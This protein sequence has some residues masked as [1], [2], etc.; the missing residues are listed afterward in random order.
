MS[1]LSKAGIATLLACAGIWL[2]GCERGYHLIYGL[3][4]EQGDWVV[5]PRF[6]KLEPPSAGLAAAST[7]NLWGFIDPGGEWT[8]EPRF[9]DVRSFSE[10][11]AAV[12][13][14]GQWRFVDGSGTTVIAGPFE[15]VQSFDGGMAAVRVGAR[16]G[17]VDHAGRFVIT[18][19]FEELGAYPEDVS[20]KPRTRCFSEGLCAVKTAAG[21]GYIDR[22]GRQVIEPVFAGADWFREGRA[23]VRVR[24]DADDGLVGFIDR[25][26]K[27]VIAPRFHGSL[28]FSGGRA[29]AVPQGDEEPASQAIMIDSEGREI[30]IV[31]WRP[32]TELSDGVAEFLRTT[33]PDYLGSGFV[34]ATRG[35]SWGFMNRQGEW[36]IEPRFGM[37]MP[38]RNGVA[39]VALDKGQELDDLLDNAEWGLLDTSGRWIREPAPLVPGRFGD[40]WLL[41]L[42]HGLQGLLDR[43]GRWRIAPRFAHEEEWIQLPGMHSGYHEG[44]LVAATF[45]NHRWVIVDR[46]GRVQQTAT[47]EWLDA[48]GPGRG[49]GVLTMLDGGRWGIADRQLRL[50]LPPQLDAEP[51]RSGSLISAVR[52]GRTGCLDLSGRWVVP[53]EFADIQDC[54]E[55]AVAAATDTGW[56]IWRAG[57]GW[58]LPPQHQAVWPL[59]SDLWEVQ[60]A[61]GWHIYRLGPRATSAVLLAGGPYAGIEY[62]TQQLSMARRGDRFGPV[63]EAQ[64]VPAEFPF[65]EFEARHMK[66]PDGGAQWLTAIRSDGHWGLLDASG[67]L[68]LP[69]RFDEIGGTFDGL[70]AVA[71]DGSWGIVDLDGPEVFAPRF[72]GVM[73]VTRNVVAFRE[74]SLWGLADRNGKVLA[75]PRF[76]GITQKGYWLLVTL[77]APPGSD[78]KPPAP[79]MGLLDQR[80]RLVV[81]P[82]YR[83]IEDFSRNLWLARDEDGWALLEKRSG[84][85]AGRLARVEKVEALAEGRA[86][87]KFSPATAGDPVYGYLD[88]GGRIIVAALYDN[89]LPFADG[90]AIVERAGKCGVIGRGGNLVLAIRYDHCNRLPGGR[91]AAAIEAPFDRE[92]WAGH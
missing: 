3:I 46:R 55:G 45:A 18:P 25:R 52:N 35:R 40:P 8:I 91:V 74:G 31:G 54:R 67:R 63:T 16:W 42:Q 11:L 44:R 90:I 9:T 15:D 50:Q 6:D 49:T 82:R 10:G 84:R 37:A 71:I 7:G 20:E 73:P 13:Q 87:V 69:A 12:R 26:G 39:A 72:A 92:R 28:W 68:R 47:F 62:A 23:A 79:L 60:S 89:A 38:F 22:S 83:S 5:E 66:A 1:H 78:G 86:I 64:P 88:E 58:L 77:P 2:A 29:I 51:Q 41:A 76:A 70:V 43:D 59:W 81:E 85:T 30:A 17:F 19:G 24:G 53:A 32:F 48:L 4:D 33:A 36:V 65:D 34:P 75:A 80:G 61:D 21:W 27:P 14:D 57:T 56:G